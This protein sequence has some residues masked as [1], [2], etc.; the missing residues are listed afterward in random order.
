MRQAVAV[1]GKGAAVTRVSQ[2]HS[3]SCLQTDDLPRAEDAGDT[4]SLVKNTVYG[5]V[6]RGCS[7]R[8]GHVPCARPGTFHI[9][10]SD[11]DNGDDNHGDDGDV[12]DSVGDD[13]VVL[14][15]LMMIVVVMMMVV[16]VVVM[17]MVMIMMVMMRVKLGALVL[18]LVPTLI[19]NLVPIC[20]LRRPGANPEASAFPQK[21]L[22][23]LPPGPAA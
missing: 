8:Q 22:T 21:A 23:H 11:N 6:R 17:M 2:G 14:V 3:T 19:C 20:V 18:L 12:D 13:E 7:S 15:M 5:K 9:R 4:M 16:V 10:W 1:V